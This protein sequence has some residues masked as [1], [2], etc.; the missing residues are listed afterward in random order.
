MVQAVRSPSS[1]YRDT[2]SDTVL[3][4]RIFDR[5]RE[6]LSAKILPMTRQIRAQQ[7]A[8]SPVLALPATSG[9]KQVVMA[10]NTTGNTPSDLTSWRI[11]LSGRPLSRTSQISDRE[12]IEAAYP[13]AYP[14]YRVFVLEFPDGRDQAP[15]KELLVVESPY[16]VFQQALSF[17]SES[18]KENL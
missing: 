4:S 15:E 3:E 11:A 8:L 6:L 5:G 10:I 7:N 16:G 13:F 9:M 2:L 14:F 17:E 12:I 18:S 1:E